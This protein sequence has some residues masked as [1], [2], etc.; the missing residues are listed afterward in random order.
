MRE[1]L[2]AEYCF[3]GNAHDTSGHGRHGVVH[4]AALTTDRFG[5]P[6]H[7]YQF[8]GIDDYVEIAPPPPLT[9][10]GLTVSAWVRYQKRNNMRGW[11]NCIIAQDDGRDDDQARRVFQLSTFSGH[12]VWH[13][14]VC[15]RDPMCKRR[16][17]P[18]VWY[19]VVAVHDRGVNR[20]Y[21]DGVLHDTVE[22]RLWTHES[23]PI[24]I[25]RKATS[26][27]YFFFRGSIDDV[28][29]YDRALNAAQ[30][31]ELL[32]EGGWREPTPKGFAGDPLS[33][34][35]GREG[36]VY[37]DLK[38]HG[39]G[40]VTG[41]IMAG[42]PSNMAMITTGTFDPATGLLRLEGGASDPK[43]R[44]PIAYTIDGMLD[45]GELTV[46]ATFN[47]YSGNFILTEDGTRLRWTRRSLRSRVG[48]LAFKVRRAVTR[49]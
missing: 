23:Q 43:T 5:R 49:S 15:N 48:A 34:W 6:S 45:D 36:V 31:G 44:E 27:A 37:L 42:R 29:I 4:G 8:D 46:C 40:G 30:I 28:R 22:H 32:H 21:V 33:G 14:M 9:S 1:G 38:Y 13:R 7:A 16:V 26:E 39:G 19:H 18:D 20:L 3:A 24:H 25:G 2:V 12:I 11:T 35:W 10:E 47:D 41:R 17:R